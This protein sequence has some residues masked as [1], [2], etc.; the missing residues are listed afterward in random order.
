MKFIS[1]AS[2]SSGNCYYLESEDTKILIDAG[3]ST[4][5]IKNSLKNFDIDIAEIDAV[6][7]TH[8][9]GDHISGVE[10]LSRNYQIAVYSNALT[11]KNILEHNFIKQ[12]QLFSSFDGLINIKDL[13]IHSFNLNHDAVSPVGYVIKDKKTKFSVI[14]DTGCITPEIYNSVKGSNAVVLESNH[15]IQM[16]T[17]GPYHYSL[18]KRILSNNGHLSNDAAG[19]CAVNLIND[20]TSELILAHISSTNNNYETVE[21]SICYYLTANNIKINEDVRVDIA[22]KNETST[23]HNF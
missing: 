17:N 8:E 20:G 18:K 22:R 14:T 2:G 21:K 1:L 9:H 23:L 3:V 6:F 12:K 16:L 10:V 11:V 15:D 4:R 5:Y 13:E 19:R 7:V